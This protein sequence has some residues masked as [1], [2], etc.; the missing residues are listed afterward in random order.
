MKHCHLCRLLR[1]S[2]HADLEDKHNAG[3]DHARGDC[4][5]AEDGG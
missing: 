1:L 4:G 5:G 3:D 2:R